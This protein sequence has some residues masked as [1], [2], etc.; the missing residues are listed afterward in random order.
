MWAH[1]VNTK[2]LL[3]LAVV[4]PDITYIEADVLQDNN[5]T[6][7]GHDTPTDLT[8]VEFLDAMVKNNKVFKLDF[9]MQS[10]VQPA[11]LA[12]QRYKWTRTIFLNGDVVQGPLGQAPVINAYYFINA[13]LELGPPNFV[14]S[15]G[16]TVG[17]PRWPSEIGYT[18]PMIQEMLSLCRCFSLTNVTFA[19]N[20][21]HALASYKMILFLLNADPTYT[22][23]L[24]G[25]ANKQMMERIKTIPRAYVDVH[26]DSKEALNLR[27]IGYLFK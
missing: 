26:E 13:C 4:N 21:V 27:L 23:T 2:Q 7:M 25:V 10:A 16:W 20:T 6:Y 22:V 8:L 18:L 9:K 14:L 19:M 3:Q 5:N 11:L 17:R 15:L 12:M 24:W 1:G